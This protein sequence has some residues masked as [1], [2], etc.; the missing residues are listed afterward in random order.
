MGMQFPKGRINL[1]GVKLWSQPDRRE[2]EKFF[3]CGLTPYS[4]PSLS[5]QSIVSISHRSG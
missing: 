4:S 3:E 1:R 2:L 5:L